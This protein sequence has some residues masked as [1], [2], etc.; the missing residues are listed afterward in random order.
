MAQ[1]LN[2]A[3]K[4]TIDGSE[5]PLPGVTI[6][7]KGTTISTVTSPDGM[8]S[9]TLP[10]LSE[11]TIEFSFLGFKTVEKTV[12]SS[13]T[14]LNV[15]LKETPMELSEEMV[16]TGFSTSVKRKNL[17]NAVASYSAEEL[18]RVSSPTIDGALSGLSPGV[19]VSANSG[20]PGGGI[21]VKLRGVSTINGAS[22]PLFVVDGV[23][24]SNAE[25][26]SGVNVVTQAGG[27]G[28]TGGQDQPSN[29]V[30]DLIPS[31]IDSIEVLKGPSAAAIY[32]S[33]ASNGVVI[34]T[35]KRGQAGKPQYE[36]S[37]SFGQ[38]SLIK[39]IGT[40]VFTYDTAAAT[41]GQ[42]AADLYWQPEFI[43]QEEALYGN[44]GAIFET[45]FST[46]GGNEKTRYYFSGTNLNDEGIVK[47]TG[48]DKASIRLNLDHNFTSR[49]TAAVNVGFT[50]SKAKR[51]LTGNDNTGTT[52]GVA[53][54]ATPSFVDLSPDADG[55]YP[56][57]PFNSSNQLHTRDVMVNEEIVNRTIASFK[58]DYNVYESAKQALDFN[59]TTGVD[60]FS[61]ETNSYF[62]NQLQFERDS[63]TPG[64][65]I[66]GETE[67]ILQNFYVN[68]TH[69]L[70]AGNNTFRTTGGIQYE[71]RDVNFLNINANNLI[72]GQSN[73]DNATNQSVVQSR[74]IQKD[75]GF[76][77][78]EEVNLGEAIF[79]TAG[80]RGDASSVNGDTKKFYTYP[81]ASASIR[82]SEYDFWQ[83]IEGSISEFKLRAAWGQTGNL[84][85]TTAKRTSFL[86]TNIGGMGGLVPGATRG[87]TEIKPE[88]SEELEVGFDG[89]FWSGR[90]TFEFSVFKQTITDLLLFRQIPPSSGNSSESFNG[91]EMEVDGTE[92]S[93]RLNPVKTSKVDWTLG[94]NYYTYEGLITKLEIPAYNTGGFATS[95]GTYRIEEGWSPT[96][97]IGLNTNPDGSI[98]KLGDE[99]PDYQI[100]WTNDV[101][102]GN[103]TLSWLLDIKEGGDVINLTKLLSD[104][105]GTTADL[106]G[107]GADRGLPWNTGDTRPWIEDGSYVKLRELKLQYSL[108][109]G[110]LKNLVYGKLSHVD[111]SLQGRNVKTWTD[112]SSYDPEVSNF[113]TVAIGRS[114]EVTPFPSSRA[115]YFNISVGL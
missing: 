75:E 64:T 47:R 61:M 109:S 43:D 107:A 31:D 63:A 113:G 22:Q 99:T 88:T 28:N 44:D 30:A 97:L 73:V 92:F 101:R 24:M 78:Q 106:D 79:I 32:G 33:K 1:D 29:R 76:F 100:G 87:N 103:W 6:I 93:V 67:S 49:L 7:V 81:K 17:A 50:R 77:I 52:F 8:Y 59:I 2:V 14:D 45:N 104:L 83:G 56:D 91:G 38:R 90:G 54:S 82:L 57:N 35:T 42:A 53:M 36:F 4:V 27:G 110:V 58:L 40:R 11:A 34:I 105:G 65:R 89:T 39:K 84:P 25:I 95:L 66:V 86:S 19:T 46:R 80:V 16:I 108:S 21:S 112:Y 55:N 3:G 71:D 111:L 20:A 102:V 60:Y 41:Y 96:S 115:W 114:V 15:S 74:G 69:T 10:G 23:I 18:N 62:P 70:Y 5:D 98:M 85:L 51:G 37:Q 94:L 48:Y 26:Q 72:D 12:T 68:L 13:S 9:L